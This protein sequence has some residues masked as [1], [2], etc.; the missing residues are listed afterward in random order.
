MSS[1]T[2]RF[3]PKTLSGR[4]RTS[5]GNDRDNRTSDGGSSHGSSPSTPPSQAQH[6]AFSASGFV[7]PSD[8]PF[9][10]GSGGSGSGSNSGGGGGD[11]LDSV[12]HGGVPH[13]HHPN[14]SH[15]A[16]ASAA[17]AAA[18]TN[19]HHPKHHQYYSLAAA[20]AQST[21]NIHGG[22]GGLSV[23]L[24]SS[25]G[26]MAGGVG[27]GTGTTSG[28]GGGGGGVGASRP[29]K[30]WEWHYKSFLQ[31][32]QHGS[33][34]HGYG[35]GTVPGS[36]GGDGGGLLEPP[37]PPLKA[38]RSL[39]ST[40]F[41]GVTSSI[42][43]AAA[44][45]SA[46]PLSV[47]RRRG[48]SSPKSPSSPRASP[49]R[50]LS[51]ALLRRSP[52][53]A[54]S[55][56]PEQAGG[57]GEGG[58]SGTNYRIRSATADG[59]T[60]LG[61][62]PYPS[63][64]PVN[65]SERKGIVGLDAGAVP[66]PPILATGSGGVT[67]TAASSPPKMPASFSKSRKGGSSQFHL[68]PRHQQQQQQQQ[69]Q[70]TS[71]SMAASVDTA[72]RGGSI[73]KSMFKH[74]S[75]S[76]GGFSEGHGEVGV[77]TAAAGGNISLDAQG[78]TYPSHPGGG[79]SCMRNKAKSY[80]SL[81]TTVRRGSEVAYGSKSVV[82]AGVQQ[83]HHQQHSYP[84]HSSQQSGKP[85]SWDPNFY[86]PNSVRGGGQ[87][88][89]G[90]VD[91]PM[92]ASDVSLEQIG[93]DLDGRRNS[94][95]HGASI[96]PHG[97]AEQ[98]HR[99]HTFM[100]D[101]KKAFTEFH[102]SKHYGKDTTS[103]Y[104]GDEPSVRANNYFAVRYGSAARATPLRPSTP[105]RYGSQGS[106]KPVT[107]GVAPPGPCALKPLSG[108][109]TWL[110]DRR[111]LI[112]PAVIA[113]CPTSVL[114]SLPLGAGGGVGAGIGTSGG[115]AA[116]ECATTEEIHPYR[117]VTIGKAFVSSIRNDGEMS[118]SASVV[119]V[120]RQNYLFEYAEGVGLNERPGA[121]AHLQNS[122]SYPHDTS[123]TELFLEY[124]ESP[125]AGG[126]TTK[127]LIQLESQSER[128]KWVRCLTEAASLK[129]EDLYDY[130]GSDEGLE[131]GRG[132]YAT[133]RPAKRKISMN[134]VRKQ[135][136]AECEGGRATDAEN[137]DGAE[138]SLAKGSNDLSS[139]T[140]KKCD[141]ALKIINKN[142]FWSRVV[143]DRERAD[144]LVRE[145]AVQATLTAQM[146]HLSTFLRLRNFFETID[147]VVLELEILQGIDLFQHV[148]SKGILEEDE[149]AHIMRDVLI[150]IDAMGRIGIAHR[151]IKPANVLMCHAKDDDG[152]AV[153]VG[154]FGMATFIGHGNLLRGRC[155][156]PGYVA[157]EILR[158]PVSSGYKNNVD[159]FSAGVALYV[160]LCGYEPFYGECDAELIASNRKASIQYPDEDWRR[161]SIEG[162]DLVERM[163]HHDPE[164]RITASEA[165]KHPWIT[166]RAPPTK[167]RTEQKETPES[168]CVVQ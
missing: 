42:S 155:G 118:Y 47:R 80:D 33:H 11:D 2:K 90:P 108:T 82:R 52:G 37:A 58:S 29:K 13:Q 133:V 92:S 51:S 126:E 123:E 28:G 53:A 165:L 121:F 19:H 83:Q 15:F 117:R 164:K 159:I 72:V 50:V 157:P 168:A 119:L 161:I 106:L 4:V 64:A 140:H 145:T 94:G 34:G 156:T 143:R 99:H 86:V 65:R 139:S 3:V 111:Y 135:S 56:T 1:F 116:L 85:R 91:P 134:N 24:P 138:P 84:S 101:I 137:D 151:D 5:S 77:R 17:A 113:V 105:S 22:S 78:P 40:E 71:S 73:F 128:N 147:H 162:R 48:G 7:G 130:D 74:G 152:I 26:G 44:A 66:P 59:V 166:R 25:Y 87:H 16:A 23:G 67:P 36:G 154:D 38:S 81:D 132:R 160:L 49:R 107:E 89:G 88:S 9:G 125:C 153:K 136:E 46:S 70:S 98:E 68:G 104:L 97:N 142:E 141:C 21:P 55:A 43:S 109:E 79:A 100:R 158:S 62:G 45:S 114:S 60:A 10:G 129:I 110:K 95:G 6:V 148:S 146:G 18:S 96:G 32:R 27:A 57:S 69:Q 8:P 12:V 127:L 103:P 30:G 14:P 115:L 20:A 150:C 102:N 131:F 124:Y 76:N 35:H 122:L 75:G 112:G 31:K 120:L 163:L 54:V 39:T 41:A 144:T 167:A 61:V 149:A 63:S 93:L